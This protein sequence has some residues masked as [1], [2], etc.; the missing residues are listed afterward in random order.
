M[1]KRWPDVNDVN[2]VNGVNNV[3]DLNLKHSMGGR[4]QYSLP[5]YVYT[6]D[7]MH[8]HQRT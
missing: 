4:L 2:V 6:S 8:T 1:A 3:N 5:Y 7:D